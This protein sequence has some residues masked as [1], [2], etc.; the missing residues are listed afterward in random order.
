MIV[1]RTAEDAYSRGRRLAGAVRDTCQHRRIRKKLETDL[2]RFTCGLKR[3]VVLN[4]LC[5]ERLKQRPQG[6]NNSESR[7]KQ[8]F[9]YSFSPRYLVGIVQDVPS[10]QNENRR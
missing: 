10:N 5:G 6:T 2:R 3:R 8:Q 4:V 1:Y 9:H 7:T